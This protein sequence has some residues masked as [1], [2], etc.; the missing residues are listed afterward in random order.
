MLGVRR[1]F[2]SDM[3]EVAIGLVFVYLLFSF[4]A[5]AARE[6]LE[7]WIKSRG[8]LLETGI[9]NLFSDPGQ[10][11]GA[12]PSPSDAEALLKAF[13]TSPAVFGLFHGPY[14]PPGARS[15]STGRAIAKRLPSYI[16][17]ESF[18][19]GVMQVVAN[20]ARPGAGGAPGSLDRLQIALEALD[21]AQ[22]R[23]IVRAAIQSAGGDPTKVSAALET[24]FDSAMDR[25]SGL[26]RR[27]TQFIVLFASLVVAV[28][29]NVNTIT[30][31]ESLTEHSAL[32]E[33]VALAAARTVNSTNASSAA[34][35]L[36]DLGLPLGWQDTSVTAMDVLAFAG[37][38]LPR[39]AG[40]H[41]LGWLLVGLGW[42]MTA[43]AISLGAPFWFDVLNKFMVVRST[44]KPVEKSGNEA[45]K[46]PT[47]A[48]DPAPGA[49]GGPP[50]LGPVRGFAPAVQ[51][52]PVAGGVS[53]A[54]QLEIAL[55]DP[56]ERPREDD[57]L[58]ITATKGP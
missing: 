40:F 39:V 54:D 44:V 16:P 6:G 8:A 13:Y 5:T 56:G 30:I 17:S 45:S 15:G 37:P 1:M 9:L 48:A 42:L 36:A 43:L 29:L 3:L 52:A 11:P 35:S 58:E 2:N 23:E 57:D 41:P 31:V 27:T 28:A 25:V 21:N 53:V 55:L 22:V 7:A 33:T 38:E 50:A 18:A 4:V 19:Q 10:R 24:W 47:S 14:K 32:R 20:F 12:T 46:D 26:Y 49:L 34:Q 51:S